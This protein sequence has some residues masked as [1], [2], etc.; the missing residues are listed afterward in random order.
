MTSRLSAARPRPIRFPTGGYCSV[1]ELAEPLL[2]WYSTNARDLPWRRPG[3]TPWGVLVSEFM[4]QQTPVSRVE[5][6]WAEWLRRWPRPSRLA[7]AT[8]AD[9]LRARYPEFTYVENKEWEQNN[10]L[11]SLMYAR[12]HFGGGFVSTY[13]DIVYEGAVV[14]D[15]VSAQGDKVLGALA[16]VGPT[17]MNYGRV[18]P[19]VQYTA[20]AVS[21]TFGDV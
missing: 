1:V 13:T 20:R 17:R 2:E 10:I 8:R 9:V 3:T 12:E 7:A 15:L 11:A 5:P 14:C 19:L 16:V 4:L 21:K 18:I 6:V